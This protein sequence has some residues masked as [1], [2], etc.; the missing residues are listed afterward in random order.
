V[1]DDSLMVVE[2]AAQGL[3]MAL[4]RSGLI[5]GDLASGRLVRPLET[6]VASDLGLFVVW[7]ADSR[8]LARIAGLRDWLLAEACATGGRL[9]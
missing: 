3:G 7:R 5:E 6:N 1:L 8:K 9:E 2:A 4:A